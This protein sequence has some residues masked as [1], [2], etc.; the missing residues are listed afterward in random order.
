MEHWREHLDGMSGY[1]WV[2]N[3]VFEGAA[4]R[5][6]ELKKEWIAFGDDEEDRACVEGFWPFEDQEEVE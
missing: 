6:R 2:R 1:G 4:E 5:N 3:E